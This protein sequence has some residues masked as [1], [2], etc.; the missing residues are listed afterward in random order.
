[1]TDDAPEGPPE[2]AYPFFL[3]FRTKDGE[4]GVQLDPEAMEGPG[5]AGVLLADFARHFAMAFAQ[6]GKASSPDAALDEILDLF[7]AEL[8]NPTDAPRGGISN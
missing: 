2:N 6:T 4:I 7:E 5:H 1:M 8:E 3:A